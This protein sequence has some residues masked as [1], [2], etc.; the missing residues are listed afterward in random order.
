MRLLSLIFFV[1]VVVLLLFP[2]I[3]KIGSFKSSVTYLTEKSSE[4]QFHDS[5]SFMAEQADFVILQQRVRFFLLAGLSL[6]FTI[7]VFFRSKPRYVRKI[8]C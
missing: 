8:N 1:F 6:I 7:I 5:V 2:P 4:E 3:N